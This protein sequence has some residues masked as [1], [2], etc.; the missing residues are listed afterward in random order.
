MVIPVCADKEH[1]QNDGDDE[2]INSSSTSANRNTPAS[3]SRDNKAG[4]SQ[5]G[6][7]ASGEASVV[8][9]SQGAV[10]TLSKEPHRMTLAA[11]DRTLQISSIS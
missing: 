3:D 1:G 5:P 11:L 2:S 9:M 10:K 4:A 8:N 7:N 6:S